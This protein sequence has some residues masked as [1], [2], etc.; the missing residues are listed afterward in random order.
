SNRCA[1]FTASH[2]AVEACRSRTV[3]RQVEVNE[4]VQ[5]GKLASVLDRKSTLRHVRHEIG[6][7]HLDGEDGGYRHREQAQ[8]DQEAA[9]K[10]EY[11][12][13]AHERNEVDAGALPVDAT[14]HAE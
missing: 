1:R 7:Q 5:Q 2:L 4:R 9:E 8:D 3:G 14:Q 10:L 6:H 13:K 11:A 12:G